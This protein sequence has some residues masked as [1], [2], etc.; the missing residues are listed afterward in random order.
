MDN[1]NKYQVAAKCIFIMR[2]QL[3]ETNHPAMREYITEKINYLCN[4]GVL[5]M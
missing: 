2:N 5:D 3:G 1:I 4:P